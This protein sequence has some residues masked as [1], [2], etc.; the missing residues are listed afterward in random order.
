MSLFGRKRGPNLPP[1]IVVILERYG[2]WSFDPPGSGIDVAQIGHDELQQPLIQAYPQGP[3]AVEAAAE[4]LSRN[5]LEVTRPAGGW[6]AYGA[7]KLVEDIAD[8]VH[9]P[10]KIALIEAG[11]EF[12]RE[13]GVPWN[14][15]LSSKEKE[16][17]VERHP[18]GA[19]R[20]GTWRTAPSGSWAGNVLPPL[21]LNI[22][23]VPSRSQDADR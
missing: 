18:G 21:T 22:A 23:W 4:E 5:L 3:Q 11:L 7:Y 16:F 13:R 20:C 17:W 19:K 14:S 12:L 10:S 8:G 1:D 15:H 6:P 2:R 9:P